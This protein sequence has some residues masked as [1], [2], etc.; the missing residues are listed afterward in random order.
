MALDQFKEYL[1]GQGKANAV[2]KKLASSRFGLNE[3]Q[4]Q[5][6]QYFNAKPEQSTTAKIHSSIYGV[7]WLTAQK[8]LKKLVKLEFL[9]R[10]KR[11]VQVLYYPVTKKINKLF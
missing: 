6:L 2:M 9:N 11:G 1:A 4:V 8:D 10:K 3:R 5:L 7:G